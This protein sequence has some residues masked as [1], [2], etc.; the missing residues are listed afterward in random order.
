[1]NAQSAL[2]VPTALTVD[3]AD[4]HAYAESLARTYNY[5]H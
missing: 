1:M 2:G 5:V 3:V 4:S